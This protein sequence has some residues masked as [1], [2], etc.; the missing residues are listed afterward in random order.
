[1]QI[2]S[3]YLMHTIS[4][5]VFTQPAANFLN[6]NLQY[7]S[8]NVLLPL[9]GFDM[10]KT[11]PSSLPCSFNQHNYAFGLCQTTQHFHSTIWWPYFPS[12]RRLG[13]PTYPQKSPKRITHRGRPYARCRVARGG[14]VALPIL[15]LPPTTQ[16]PFKA[17][18]HKKR[19]AGNETPPALRKTPLQAT[20]RTAAHRN[21]FQSG[22]LGKLK[23]PNT[24]CWIHYVQPLL[25]HGFGMYICIYCKYYCK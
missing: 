5:R 14:K 17:L 13:T 6:A 8:P 1:M 9:L 21:V 11:T 25:A 3:S 4:S 12:P 2:S 24:I 15:L 20:A 18:S 23:L 16:V 7:A 19:D 10:E 22:V